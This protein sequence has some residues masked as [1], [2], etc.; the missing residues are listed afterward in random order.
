MNINL[1]FFINKVDNL[2][3]FYEELIRPKTLI[4]NNTQFPIADKEKLLIFG[5]RV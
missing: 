4:P 5:F 3:E 1:K 2:Y